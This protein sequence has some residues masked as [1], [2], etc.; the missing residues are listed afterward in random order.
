MGLVL[1]N[2]TVQQFAEA[3]E[4]KFTPDE[5]EL[6]ESARTDVA[7]FTDPAAF[8]IFD[9]PQIAVYLGSDLKSDSAVLAAFVAANER[10][11]FSRVVSFYPS[12]AVTAS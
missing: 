11:E 4:A 5:I 8:H 7:E 9:T 1:G 12:P 2:L 6:L 3:V 10:S